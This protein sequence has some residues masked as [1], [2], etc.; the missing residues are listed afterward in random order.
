MNDTCIP[1]KV[2]ENKWY[3]IDAKDQNLGRLS[4]K[5]AI[6]L[7]G[8]NNIEYTPYMNN[9]SYVIIKNAKYINITGKKRFQKTYK[10]HSGKPGGLKTETFEELNHRIPARIIEKAVKGM[11]PKGALGR[12][13]FIQLKVYS[14]N[15]H[16]H[17]AQQPK[18]ISLN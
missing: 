1:N 9:L 18:I 11:L 6:I 8:K 10:R 4:T 2:K 7:R 15:N 16:P 13:L 5:I 17:S 14:G 12:Q 3:L